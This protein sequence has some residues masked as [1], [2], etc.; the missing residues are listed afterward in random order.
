MFFMV[1]NFQLYMSCWFDISN[2]I[3]EEDKGC[4]IVVFTAIKFNIWFM[5]DK[6][7]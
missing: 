6:I 2:I 4:F 3:I 1:C 5:H 7:A